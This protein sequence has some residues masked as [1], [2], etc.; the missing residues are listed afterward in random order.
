[1]SALVSRIS[2]APTPL[3]VAGLLMIPLIG[4]GIY[5]L[6]LT[7]T[8]KKEEAKYQHGRDVVVSID[9]DG[10]IVFAEDVKLVLFSSIISHFVDISSISRS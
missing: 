9:D 7:A 10:D 1:M 8:K 6:V 2:A 3:K 4:L 5:N